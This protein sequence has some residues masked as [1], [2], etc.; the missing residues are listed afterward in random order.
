MSTKLV[1]SGGSEN[2]F[3]RV[4]QVLQ[5]T[6]RVGSGLLPPPSSRG[7]AASL[8]NSAAF[9]KDPCNYVR[10]TQSLQDNLLHL[11][12]LHFITLQI[13]ILTGPGNQD[14]DF[15]GGG[16]ILS[17]TH[18]KETA[19]TSQIWRL[20]TKEFPRLFM[21]IQTRGVN[22]RWCHPKVLPFLKDAAS[23]KEYISAKHKLSS[24][25]HWRQL[26]HTISEAGAS[27][28]TLRSVWWKTL[29]TVTNL[30][31]ILIEDWLPQMGLLL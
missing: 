13:T 6:W 24:W 26:A 29:A 18:N 2:P 25:G 8:T 19:Y 20:V 10:P 31:S 7:T 28:R 27:H 14:T 22:K 15:F 12:I 9:Y 3:P 16:T 5:T 1:P 30:I 11:K 4:S 23:N 21:H 17:T